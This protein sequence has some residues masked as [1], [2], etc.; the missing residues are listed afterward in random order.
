MVPP[1]DYVAIELTDSGVGITGE[2]LAKIFE[3]FYTT[4]KVGEGTGL[5]LSTVYGIIKQTGGFI[6]PESRV[7]EGTTFRIYF[8]VTLR[9]PR[10]L[11]RQGPPML[12]PGPRAISQARAWC[13]W[14]RTKP[15]SG[16]LLPGLWRSGLGGRSP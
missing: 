11:P 15:R 12:R 14:W 8:P 9:Q 2:N 7:G 1:G 16:G 13:C 10:S 5:G 6:I 4:K 3:P